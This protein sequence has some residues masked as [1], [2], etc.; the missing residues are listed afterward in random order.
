MSELAPEQVR[1]GGQVG[2]FHGHGEGAE[3]DNSRDLWPYGEARPVG[4]LSGGRSALAVAGVGGLCRVDGARRS[5]DW[6]GR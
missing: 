3:V 5:S 4:T 2:V 1:A 6:V